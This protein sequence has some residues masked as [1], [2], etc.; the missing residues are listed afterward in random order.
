MF[1][2]TD[3]ILLGGTHERDVWTLDPDAAQT[4]RILRGNR[5]LFSGMKR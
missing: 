4:A 3:G 2:R 1:P 5:D